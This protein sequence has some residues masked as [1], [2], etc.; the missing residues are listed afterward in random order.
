MVFDLK[1]KC[2]PPHCNT[3]A[4]RTNNNNSY[5]FSKFRNLKNDLK[6][7]LDWVA[8]TVPNEVTEQ[9]LFSLLGLSEED[10]TE[11][12]NGLYGY[13]RQK[14]FGH[15]IYLCDGQYSMGKHIEMSGQGVRE[16]ETILM[17]D[18]A[19]FFNKA[20]S[21]GAQFT[22]IDLAIDDKQEEGIEG[23]FKVNDI[24]DG[25]KAGECV[26]RFK[27]GSLH[28][29]HDLAT[30]QPISNTYYLGSAKSRI[31]F[32]IYDKAQEQKLEENI[33]W[34]RTEIQARNERAH[35][36]AILLSTDYPVGELASGV[37]SNYVSFREQN[38]RDSNRRRWP[39]VQWWA[40][41][42]GNVEKIK[43][44]KEQPERTIKN[45]QSW[46]QTQVAPS[47]ALLKLYYDDDNTMI[48]ILTELGKGKL[49]NRHLKLL[50]EKKIAYLNKKIENPFEN[51]FEKQN[52]AIV[53]IDHTKENLMQDINN[54]Q[55]VQME[56]EK[57][58]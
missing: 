41:F 9:K 30:G 20:L 1:E 13:R 4:E 29:D 16:F 15:I 31:R 55:Y 18:W 43:L 49:T 12:P 45:V 53:P 14:R 46:V 42:I 17:G 44:T 7:I 50:D 51:T 38:Y 8:F 25:V 57:E 52:I 27:T 35:E 48:N 36:I 56:L 22:R 26:S 19:G 23:F 58:K 24:I 34:V 21:L 5:L 10:F 40:D 33:H 3:G 6:C 37:I 11:M 54:L 39:V 47:L 2:T 32:R 28:Q